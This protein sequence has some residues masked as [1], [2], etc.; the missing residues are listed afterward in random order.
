MSGVP[1]AGRAPQT[2]AARFFHR[3]NTLS[4]AIRAPP[5]TPVQ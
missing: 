4:P 5:G 2:R 3:V 1:R